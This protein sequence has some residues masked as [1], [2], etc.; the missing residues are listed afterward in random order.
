MASCLFFLSISQAADHEIRTW[1]STVG[2]TL[3][4]RLIHHD[5]GSVTL[6]REDGSVLTVQLDQL[7]AQDRHYVA[8][9]PEERGQ[10]TI[11]G[12]DAQPGKIS[13]KNRCE[14][15]SQWSYH[16]YLPKDFHDARKWPVLFV[17]AP[18]GGSGGGSLK[19]YIEGAETLGFILALSVES[20]NGFA[21]SHE[22]MKAMVEDVYERLPVAEELSFSSGFSGGS[23]MAYSLAEDN[24]N[25]KGVIACGSGS[26]IYPESGKFRDAKLRRSTYV[27]SLIGSNCFN[28]TGAY[29]SHEDFPEHFRLRFF[30][31]NHVWA[32]APLIQEA[33][34]RV[35]GEALKDSREPVAK[36][37]RDRFAKAAWNMTQSLEKDQPWE[38]YYW[39]EFLSDFPADRD[40]RNQSVAL[41]NRLGRD[42]RVELA[43]EA[44]EAIGELGREF[45]HDISY[46][47]DQQDNPDRQQ[48]ADQLASDFESIPHAELIRKL[49]APAR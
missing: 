46:Q 12:I 17:M 39:A 20:R 37:L 21:N 42:S 19:R 29:N 44:E 27:Y 18:G 32:S 23:R 48:F 15:D 3:N 38:A 13:P 25:I 31:G 49:G 5:S 10:T 26:G 34:A 7:S 28:R 14:S 6:E 8:T 22:A 4:A 16:L 30:P 43:Q 2:S 1:T 36:E 41:K 11:A 47:K 24:P 40:I 9:L 35:L 45:Y 33:M